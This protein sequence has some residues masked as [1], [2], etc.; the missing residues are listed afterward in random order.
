LTLIAF[1]LQEGQIE[2]ATSNGEAQLSIDVEDV[3]LSKLWIVIIE[4][5]AGT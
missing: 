4:Y 2:F 1:A 3:D 5:N